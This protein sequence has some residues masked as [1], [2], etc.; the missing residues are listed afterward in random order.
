[1]CGKK[2][3]TNKMSEEKTHTNK[4]SEKKTH[5]NKMCG[6]LWKLDRGYVN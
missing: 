3:H 4:M 6:R 1:M 5:T 2:T